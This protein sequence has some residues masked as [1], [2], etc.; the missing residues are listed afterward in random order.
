MEEYYKE[1]G[2]QDEEDHSKPKNAKKDEQALYKKTKKAKPTETEEEPVKGKKSVVEKIISNAKEAPTYSS[3]TRVIKIVKQ[4]FNPGQEQT[5]GDE[6]EKKKGKT[7][8]N[9]VN[10]SG[11]LNSKEYKSL[12]EFFA[13]ELPT[14]VLKVA[15]VGLKAFNKDSCDIKKAYGHLSSKQQVLLKTYAANYNKLLSQV[16]EDGSSGKFISGLLV[17]GSDVVKCCLPFG[18]YCK[19]L[20]TSSSRVCV[21]Y[22]QMSETSQLLGFN[23]L[24]HLLVWSLKD[25]P[26]LFEFAIKKMYNEFTK[27]CKVGG[28]GFQ[29]QDNLRVAQNCFVELL[30]LNLTASYQLGFLYIRQ[31]CLHLRNIRNNLT[32]DAIKNIYS[33]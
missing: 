15:N 21:M 17:S 29:I 22:H 18:I 2:I 3:V 12:M 32:K 25:T 30:G 23:M 4:V 8:K 33:W 9:K 20:I 31:L 6:E 16:L 14:L 1:L 26:S 19:K 13:A 27:F 24:R 28:G 10:I 5:E 11:L 7:N